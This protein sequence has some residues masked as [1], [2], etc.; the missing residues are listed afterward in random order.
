M[1]KVLI[2]EETVTNTGQAHAT[3]ANHPGDSY[4]VFL[5]GYHRQMLDRR[6]APR[7]FLHP[8]LKIRNLTPT[9]DVA[10][11]LSLATVVKIVVGF[12]LFFFFLKKQRRGKVSSMSLSIVLTTI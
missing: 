4:L 2:L 10:V 6:S 3:L 8:F 7:V 1:D 12:S 5:A 9:V 11:K